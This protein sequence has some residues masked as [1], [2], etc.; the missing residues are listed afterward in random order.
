MISWKMQKRIEKLG[1]GAFFALFIAGISVNA[2]PDVALPFES[3]FCPD[4]TSVETGTQ[5]SKRINSGPEGF[6]HCVDD[7]GQL[8]RDIM[9]PVFLTIFA[10]ATV[11]CTVGVT[12]FMRRRGLD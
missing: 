2:V 6:A 4:G 3:L 9:V 8:Q 12:A 7:G 1:I 5:A 10:A 11:V